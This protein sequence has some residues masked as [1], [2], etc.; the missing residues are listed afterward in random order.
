MAI[1]MKRF[2]DITSGSLPPGAS[3]R[4]LILRLVT[5]SSG[6]NNQVKPD[7]VYECTSAD[8]VL[9]LFGSA[10]N[11]Y[12]IASKYFGF[13]SL[14]AT[15]AQKI[16]FWRPLPKIEEVTMCTVK[17]YPEVDGEPDLENPTPN[18]ITVAAWEAIRDR[19]NENNKDVP[20]SEGGT[21]LYWNVEGDIAYDDPEVTQHGDDIV[22]SL[23]KMADT[24]DNFA[25]LM[26]VTQ[27]K[28]V[29]NQASYPLPIGEDGQDVPYS[30][31]SE[32]NA[33]ASWIN[34]GNYRFRAVFHVDI[35]SIAEQTGSIT[36]QKKT[37]ADSYLQQIKYPCCTAVLDDAFANVSE[38]GASLG[39]TYPGWLTCALLASTK[40][41]R[42]N[43]TIIQEFKA[44]NSEDMVVTCK[45]D[46][47]YNILTGLNVNFYGQ[48]Q[49]AGQ[50]MAF[51]M[52]G[53]N[54]DGTDTS[55]GDNEIWLKDRITTEVFNRFVKCNK[56]P[57]GAVGRAII[58]TAINGV[59]AEGLNNLSV[60]PEKTISDEDKAAII[61][62]T[63]ATDAPAQIYTQGYY[64]DV[65]DGDNERAGAGI[66]RVVDYILY[67]STG[68]GI[69]KV[70]GSHVMV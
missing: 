4:E 51:Y 20:V 5:T 46:S 18:H 48:T 54:L 58:K 55:V 35:E 23:T 39:T 24:S 45:C 41:S 69:R 61:Q 8:D 13:I 53:Y 63:G 64:L 31:S 67:Y 10:S 16:S 9:G 68:E 32:A 22:T 50:L 25:T 37:G 38:E 11:E 59:I 44:L 30:S 33:V 6:L 57:A 19:L 7:I 42:A 27:P 12:K 70:T 47:L 15:K 17:S 1:S 29:L 62:N 52:E 40:Y 43:S 3:D 28:M 60:Q 14:S 66:R 21:G 2:V 26:F 49:K 65:R 36:W 34:G 56:V